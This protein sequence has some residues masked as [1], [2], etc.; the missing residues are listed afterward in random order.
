MAY[1]N[2]EKKKIIADA[3]KPILKKYGVKATLSVENRSTIN[4]NINSSKFDFLG[5]EH[6]YGSINLYRY[7]EQYSEECLEFLKEAH[8]A[9][10]SAGWYDESDIMTDYFNV[11]YYFHINIGRWDRKYQ[12]IA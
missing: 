7:N 2:Q 1:M 8:G 12:R 9:L 5:L 10:M 3:M 6:N 4:L 11:A